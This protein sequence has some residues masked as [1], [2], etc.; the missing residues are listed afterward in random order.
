M[1]CGSHH[2]NPS[3]APVPH[4]QDYVSGD[5][6]S[7]DRFATVKHIFDIQKQEA[8]S[9]ENADLVAIERI[10]TAVGKYL[11]FVTLD[12]FQVFVDRLDNEEVAKVGILITYLIPAIDQNI[13]KLEVMLYV[14]G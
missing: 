10:S 6:F 11:P 9:T 1:H 4:V 2:E 3:L 7:N 13:R 5:S 14:G 12:N 8:T